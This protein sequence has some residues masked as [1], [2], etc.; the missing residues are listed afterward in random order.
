MEAALR[1]LVQQRAGNRCEY[2]HLHQIR[3]PY[4]TFHVDHIT[5]RKHGGRDDPS[6]LA[7]ACNRCNRYKGTNL[8]GIDPVSGNI[9]PLFHPRKDTW[10]VH[11]EFRGVVLTGLTPEGR[12]TIRVLNMN[13]HGRL[14]LRER[15]IVLGQLD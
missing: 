12:A 4:S 11:F 5:P 14:Q 8:T 9:T 1:R 13:D 3:A 15:L 10:E 6:N 7:F 2:C